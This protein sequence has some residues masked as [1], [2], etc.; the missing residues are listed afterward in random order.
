MNTP[1]VNSI[2]S[3]PGASGGSDPIDRDLDRPASIRD[4]IEFKASVERA[5]ERTIGEVHGIVAQVDFLGPSPADG[6]EQRFGAEQGAASSL[7]CKGGTV[8]STVQIPVE[9]HRRLK[10]L[11]L[12]T[13]ESLNAQLLVAIE[14]YLVR[15]QQT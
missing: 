13:G 3:E 8:K 12:D 14:E 15:R 2:D 11:A 7:P 1:P 9:K 6:S 10:E 5:L 4:L